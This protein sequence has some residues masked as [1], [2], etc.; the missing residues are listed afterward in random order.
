MEPEAVVRCPICGGTGWKINEREGVRSA[1]RCD[2]FQQATLD[3]LLQKAEIPPRY[4]SCSFENFNALTERLQVAK[5]VAM[6]FVQEYPL[7]DCGLL[8]MGPCGVGKTHLAVSVLKELIWK[9]EAEG[10]FYD[11][12]DLLKKIQ[13]SY[14]SVSQTSEMQILEPVLECQVLVLDDLGAERPTEWVRDT[15]AYIVNSRYNRKLTTLITTNFDDRPKEA[16]TL[17]DG[18]RLPVEDNSLQQRIGE[19]LRSRL[20]EMCK[21]IRIDGADDFRIRIKQEQYLKG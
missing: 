14:N 12:R 13:N 16:R 11:F 18:T 4:E 21:V 6:K 7:V 17:A 1:T 8:I 2:C 20:Y 15:I 19:R 5:T 9:R 10:L 3:R